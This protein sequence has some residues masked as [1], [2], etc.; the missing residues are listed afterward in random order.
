MRISRWICCVSLA[1]CGAAL[2]QTR[3]RSRRSRSPPRRG[4]E[5]DADADR[6]RAQ[7]KARRRRHGDTH[8]RRTCE[9]PPAAPSRHDARRPRH[10]G[11]S[12][13]RGEQTRAT[14]PPTRGSASSSKPRCCAM[15]KR[16][17]STRPS[18]PWR[19]PS[20]PR[21]AALAAPF[22]RRA[23]RAGSWRLERAACSA[24]PACRSSRRRPP[25]GI[26][27][28]WYRARV[29]SRSRAARSCCWSH[30]A[31]ERRMQRAP[32]PRSDTRASASQASARLDG[33]LSG[34]A[35]V[36]PPRGPVDPIRD[37]GVQSFGGS[38]ARPAR[39]R[40]ARRGSVTVT[41]LR[42]DRHFSADCRRL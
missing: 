14:R 17:R 3:N 25:T 31:R 18:K 33:F 13:E 39:T 42:S 30:A 2:A 38:G 5:C 36:S 19:R 29:T 41:S 27:H 35:R 15:G 9:R 1:W 6:R 40:R 26:R 24:S 16:C 8:G 4:D 37:S 21:R 34:V 23:R 7:S 12:R 32:A 20:R 22:G 11:A 10:G 28:C